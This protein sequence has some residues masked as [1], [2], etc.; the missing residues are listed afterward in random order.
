MNKTTSLI[1]LSASHATPAIATCLLAGGVISTEVLLSAYTLAGL[2]Y[3]TATDYSPRTVCNS[4]A[5]ARKPNTSW[6]RCSFSRS[7]RSLCIL[8]AEKT[9]PKFPSILTPLPGTPD[10]G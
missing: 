9:S 4:T 10:L 1:A 5:N 7:S 8:R 2:F 6:I 3:V